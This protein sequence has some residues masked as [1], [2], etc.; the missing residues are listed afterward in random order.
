MVQCPLKPTD[1]SF[2]RVRP[3]TSG[4]SMQL[5]R[6]R[7][8]LHK[9][10]PLGTMLWEAAKRGVSNWDS[11]EAWSA[12]HKG[13][14]RGVPLWDHINNTSAELISHL[15]HIGCQTSLMS[16]LHSLRRI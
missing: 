10:V 3:G 13:R 6:I 11:G 15:A 8:A 2:L 16:Y 9:S 1:L 7:H 4:P 14:T 5:H 12:K